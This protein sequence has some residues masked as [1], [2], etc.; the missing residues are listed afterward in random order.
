MIRA[1]M[2]VC[3][4]C[5]FFSYCCCCFGDFGLFGFYQR[6]NF[7]GSCFHQDSTIIPSWMLVL[8]HREHHFPKQVASP[9]SFTGATFGKYY[10]SLELKQPWNILCE[11]VGL[12]EAI[13][14]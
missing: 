9:A 8:V 7:P 4:C 14:Q 1:L 13:G 2:G 10:C 12:Q 3:V 11:Q 6:Q 5:F